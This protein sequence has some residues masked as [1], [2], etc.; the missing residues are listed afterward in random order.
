M[1]LAF[2][3]TGWPLRPSPPLLGGVREVAW[4]PASPGL[5][6]DLSEETSS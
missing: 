5:P 2:Q 6:L 4:A 3:Q 1:Q